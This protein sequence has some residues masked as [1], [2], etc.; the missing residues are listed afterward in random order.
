MCKMG[1][2][3]GHRTSQ[4]KAL[5]VGQMVTPSNHD[6]QNVHLSISIK[7]ELPNRTSI[8]VDTEKPDVMKCVDFQYH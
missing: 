4:T 1:K 8:E 5:E 7:V 3:R 2:P 6:W